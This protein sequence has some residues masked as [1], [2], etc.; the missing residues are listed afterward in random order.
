[1]RGGLEWVGL[2]WAGLDGMS[3]RWEGEDGGLM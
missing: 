1:M 2:G 3:D